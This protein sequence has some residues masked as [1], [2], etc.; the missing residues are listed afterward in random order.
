MNTFGYSKALNPISLTMMELM[1]T[2]QWLLTYILRYFLSNGELE[3]VLTCLTCWWKSYKPKQ[4]IITFIQGSLQCCHNHAN[5]RL[6]WLHSTLA[7]LFKQFPLMY[8]SYQQL[9]CPD[10]CLWFI[11]Q[12][13]VVEWRKQ[14]AQQINQIN[15]RWVF[16]K[17]SK[18]TP[19][20]L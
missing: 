12:W 19:I 17:A 7:E 20:S 15:K 3:R 4:A 1:Q 13:R 18:C 14:K 11:G 9:R 16:Q 10:D 6:S 8:C 2:Q 5:V